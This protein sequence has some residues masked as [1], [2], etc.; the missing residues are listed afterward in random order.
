MRACTSNAGTG[1]F[2]T[3]QPATRAS[4]SPERAPGAVT[5]P[6]SPSTTRARCAAPVSAAGPAWAAARSTSAGAGPPPKGGYATH[7]HSACE[8][9]LAAGR[10]LPS[11]ETLE[12]LHRETPGQRAALAGFVRWLRETHDVALALPPRRSATTLKQ[13]RAKARR[14]LL[15]LLGEEA[16]GSDFGERWRVA[17]LAYFHDLALK[18]AR[19]VRKGEVEPGS[20]RAV[21][22]HQGERVLDPCATKYGLRTQPRYNP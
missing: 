19:E 8:A 2:A 14:E 5:P 18:T 11:Q 3:A 6:G 22:Q 9:A 17:A 10:E 7:A 4:S 13:R 21:H 20:R 12:A 16:G 15:S 1:G